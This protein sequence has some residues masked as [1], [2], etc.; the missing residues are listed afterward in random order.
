MGP[1]DIRVAVVYCKPGCEDITELVL[2]SGTT[3]GAAVERSGMLARHAELNVG[4]LDVGV[5]GRN[6]PAEQV[7]ADGDRVELYR[8]LTV[9]PKEARRVRA[10]LRRLRKKT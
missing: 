2:P 4:P 5:W 7:L 3:V 9:D 8:P 10:A 1:A 6:A